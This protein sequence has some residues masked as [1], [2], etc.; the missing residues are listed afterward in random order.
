MIQEQCEICAN[1]PLI[2]IIPRQAVVSRGTNVLN[3]AMCE[4]HWKKYTDD[5]EDFLNT[6]A[7]IT[8]WDALNW[9]RNNRGILK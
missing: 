3:R 9:L 4:Q 8:E 5:L 6:L 7:S 1:N 2:G